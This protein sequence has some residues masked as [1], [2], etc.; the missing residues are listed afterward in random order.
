MVV[1]L[2]ILNVSYGHQV[3]MTV[4]LVKAVMI[5]EENDHC[6]AL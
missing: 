2:A 5:S 1:F 3:R 4:H 6:G